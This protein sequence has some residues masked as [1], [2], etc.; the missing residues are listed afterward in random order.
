[1]KNNSNLGERDI[2]FHPIVLGTMFL[3]FV[4]NLLFKKYWPSLLTGKLSDFTWLF[5]TPIVIC[6]LATWIIPPKFVKNAHIDTIIWLGTGFLYTLVK[7]VPLVNSFVINTISKT[8]VPV[9]I[10]I[11]PT[12]LLALISLLIS[13]YFWRTTYSWS[14]GP[15]LPRNLLFLSLVAL[16]TMADMAAEDY[17]ISCFKPVDNGIVAA[18]TYMNYI[19]ADGGKTWNAYG[20][21]PLC[22]WNVSQETQSTEVG[23][24]NLRARFEPGKPIEISVDGGKS[25]KIGYQFKLDTQAQQTYYLKFREGNPVYRPGPFDAIFEQHTGNLLF[26]M[27]QEGILIRRPDNTWQWINVG[28]YKKI[29]YSSPNL[30]ILLWGEGVLALVNGWLIFVFLEIMVATDTKWQIRIGEFIFTFLAWISLGITAFI[31]PPA[32]SF[33]YAAEVSAGAIVGTICIS[34]VASIITTFQVKQNLA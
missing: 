34:L 21:E 23:N 7:V 6:S 29:D 17:G 8:G 10:V 28:K 1:M 30:Y 12:D 2:L 5:F 32:L 27:G 4:N 24:D 19:S 18:S 3:Y 15:S 13:F 20:G 9:A 11:D 33:G 14:R 22:G 16:L 26:A 25:W 31:F